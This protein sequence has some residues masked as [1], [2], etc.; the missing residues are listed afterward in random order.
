MI[1]RLT[2]TCLLNHH[3]TSSLY[4][5]IQKLD[6]GFGFHLCLHIGMR[7]LVPCLRDPSNYLLTSDIGQSAKSIGN[8]YSRNN[9]KKTPIC[10]T[11]ISHAFNLATF[12]VTKT[13]CSAL[14]FLSTRTKSYVDVD[15]PEFQ[16][17]S[18]P[19]E[20]DSQNLCVEGI[21]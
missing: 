18:G 16:H 1:Q 7:P 3:S 11:V 8:Y 14:Q 10:V 6:C 13:L 4:M 2:L 5:K 19:L 20:H 17:T 12:L 9:P 15:F 21:V